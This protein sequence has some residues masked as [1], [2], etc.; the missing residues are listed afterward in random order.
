M[1][2]SPYLPVQCAACGKTQLAASQVGEVPSCRNCGAPTAFVPGESYTEADV[3]LFERIE[4]AIH[5]VPLSRR[6]AERVVTELR[7]V[8]LRA[9]APEAILLRIVDFLPSLH[10]LIPA[11]YLQPSLLLERSMLARAA[12]MVRTIVST[13]LRGLESRAS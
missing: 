6:T 2:T 4:A 13:R 1:A 10:F 7:D 5:P 9:E 3:P 8:A 11:L 12:G